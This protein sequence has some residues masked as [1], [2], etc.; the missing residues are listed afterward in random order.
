[1]LLPQLLMYCLNGVL[2][3]TGNLCTINPP[4]PP[5]VKYYE[6]GKSCYVN[7]TFYTKCEDRLNGTK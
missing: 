5:V 4:N 3:S 2:M 7:G 1:M 6:S